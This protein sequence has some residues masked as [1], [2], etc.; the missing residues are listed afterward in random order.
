MKNIV[1]ILLLFFSHSLF[2]QIVVLDDSLKQPII[3]VEVYSNEG[4]LIG[5]T[6]HLGEIDISSKHLMA[7]EPIFLSHFLYEIK[8]ITNHTGVYYL[9]SK[10]ILL[11][12]VQVIAKR[13]NQNLVLKG[14]F[15]STQFR[16]DSLEFFHDGII[17]VLIF[18]NSSKHV[19]YRILQERDIVGRL[20]KMAYVGKK[21]N[22]GIK[23]ITPPIIERIQQSEFF[24]LDRL[25]ILNQQHAEVIT[26]T[27]DHTIGNMYKVVN[28]NIIQV[29][30][31]EISK[32]RPLIHKGFG[33][34]S[35]IIQKD[36]IAVLNSGAFQ[37]ID[38]AQIIYF[39]NIHKLKFRP[40]DKKHFD[41]YQAISEFFVE[42]VELQKGSIKGFTS[43]TILKDKSNVIDSY[44]VRASKHPNFKPLPPVID[45]EINFKKLN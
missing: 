24:S 35:Q 22:F 4:S 15:R 10:G 36:E 2:S 19:Q 40:K 3:G 29:E 39:K 21:M 14:Y 32:N 18:P 44:W 27:S 9:K 28:S 43:S 23:I 42:E 25:N 45:V 13:N 26:S 30:F 41:E 1:Y 16:N 37:N 34:E 31:N 6:N 17:E 8:Q 12:D 11:S 33:M 7:D 38:P 20:F 5:I